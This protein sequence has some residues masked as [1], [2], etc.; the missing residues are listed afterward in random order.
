MHGT[1]SRLSAKAFGLAA[2]AVSARSTPAAAFRAHQAGAAARSRA[3][4]GRS[5]YTA[6]PPEHERA[7]VPMS[8]EISGAPGTFQD[9][10]LA[11]QRY[12][13]GRGCVLMQPY[14]M[15]VGAGTF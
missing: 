8:S 10:I 7:V 3:L 1:R 2:R 4:S 9:L 5:V 15:E 14:D 11:L 13:A 6:R 12:W